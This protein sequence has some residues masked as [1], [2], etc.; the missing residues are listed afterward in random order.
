VKFASCTLQG[1]VLT[2][3]NSHMRAV[4][5]DVA[6]AMPWAALKRMITDKYYSRESTKVERYIGGLPNMIHDSVKASKPQSMQEAIEFATE[7]MDKKMLTHAERDKKP[8]RGTKPLCIKCNYHHDGP[9]TPKCTNC[10]KIGHLAHDCK[11]RPTA[12]N[13]NNSNNNNPNNNNQRAQG[14]NAKG[15]RDGNGNVVARAY[16]VGTAG[17]NPES[18]VVT[19]T[20]LLN[21]CYALIFFDTGADRSFISTAFSSLIDIIPTTLDHGYDVELADLRIIW[22]FPEDLPGIPPTRQVEF[23]IDLVP[24][25][26]PVAR[27]PYRLAP[28][29]MMEILDQLKELANKG[30]IR[31]SSSPWG[32]TVLFVKKKDGSFQMRIDY[33]E[34]NKLTGIHVDPAKIDSIKDWASPKTAT[35]ICQFLGLAGKASVVAD[36]LSQKVRIKPLRV[37]ALVMTTGLDLPKQILEAQTEAM[38]PENL[39]SEDVGGMLIENSKDLEKPRNEKLE[40]RAD[41]TLC[42]NNRSWLPCYGNLRTLIMH[43]SH[44]S[45]YSVHSDGVSEGYGHS[46]GYEYSARHLPLVKFSYNNSYHASINVS[47]F[48]ALYVQKCR[49]P[50]CWVEVRD[51]QLTGPEL[52]HETTEKI[53]QIKK[54]I[55]AARDHQKSY[56]NVTCNPLKFQVGERVMLKVSPWKGVARFG[57]RGKL[58]PRYIRP[59]KVLAKVG[60]V[61]F[62]LELPEQLSRVHSTFYV[63]NLKKCLSDETLAISL[64]EVHIDDKLRFIK[65]PVE[66]MD[67]EVK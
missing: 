65:E 17:T 57:K 19:G 3:W 66:V 1:S 50:V 64:D 60:T 43:E 11:G 40:P 67:R 30:F 24:G 39:K 16:V 54:R 62:R 26:A 27:A 37:R 49:S 53:V 23:Q 5:Q 48:E 59:F 8:H 36:A 32:A 10:K 44:K 42:L 45:K 2:W 9:Y 41:G 15:N 13:N 4:G 51:A 46:V 55:Q 61:S 18:N 34:L 7:M 63:S 58:N 31:P 47:P 25:A 52:I 33:R 28:S 12:A 29:K 38:K 21:N 14:A 20:F 6:Y 35:E 22:V 56:A